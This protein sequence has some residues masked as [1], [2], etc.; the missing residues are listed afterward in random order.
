MEVKVTIIFG[1]LGASGATVSKVTTMQFVEIETCC[2]KQEYA[3]GNWNG[4][5]EH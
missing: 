2:T 1:V 4:R 5:Q 3:K